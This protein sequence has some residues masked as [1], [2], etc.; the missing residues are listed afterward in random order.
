MEIIS[1]HITTFGKVIEF[2][3]GAHCD[4]VFTS[5]YSL[6]PESHVVFQ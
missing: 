3:D 4:I 5:F 2:N 6:R 1:K